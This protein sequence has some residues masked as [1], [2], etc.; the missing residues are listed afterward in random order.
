MITQ[1]S[2]LAHPII[3]LPTTFAIIES[4]P[5]RFIRLSQNSQLAHPIIALSCTIF[6][7]NRDILGGLYDYRKI[8]QLAH[9]DNCMHLLD[10]LLR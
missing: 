9:N 7:D 4:F 8:S 3:A 6:C 2:Q 1:N 5:R 10:N